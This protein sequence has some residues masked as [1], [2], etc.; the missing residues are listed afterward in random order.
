MI[1]WKEQKSETEL[2]VK[3]LKLSIAHY[4]NPI[5]P[6][7]AQWPGWPNSQLPIRNLLLYDAQTLWLLVRH[8]LTKV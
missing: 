6:R 3:H 8:V 5:G 1:G 2:S 7:G 4:F